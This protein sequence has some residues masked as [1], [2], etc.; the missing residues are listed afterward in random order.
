MF[1]KGTKIYVSGKMA[2][3]KWQ[4]QSGEDRYSTEINIDKLI[5]L[6]SPNNNANSGGN[7]GAASQGEQGFRSG[8]GTQG[9]Q[10]SFNDDTDSIPF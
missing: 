6:D 5:L 2:T 3:R 7:Y 10:S 9:G 1:K 4:T 8:T